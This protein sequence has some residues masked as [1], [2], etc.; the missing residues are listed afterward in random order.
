M[1][2]PSQEGRPG[3]EESS[4]ISRNTPLGGS[5]MESLQALCCRWS[6]KLGLGKQ[7]WALL[8]ASGDQVTGGKIGTPRPPLP[9]SPGPSHSTLRAICLH[10]GSKGRPQVPRPQRE[11]GLGRRRAGG[12][13]AGLWHRSDLS[14]AWPTSLNLTQKS[15]WAP[16]QS[17]SPGP[18]GWSLGQ[19][20]VLPQCVQGLQAQHGLGCWCWATRLTRLWAAAQHPHPVCAGEVAGPS[21][22]WCAT[23]HSGTGSGGSLSLGSSEKLMEFLFTGSENEL[24]KHSR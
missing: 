16:K 1:C 17:S 22:P 12:P 23:L 2:S 10:V 9:P 13:L 21:G 18:A 7:T 14:S 20:S 5:R 15:F 6:P 4:R 19:R 24:C 3:L 11:L 8:T